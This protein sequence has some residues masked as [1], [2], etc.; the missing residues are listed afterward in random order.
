MQ[1]FRAPIRA[2]VVAL[3]TFL[4][5]DSVAASAP[6]AGAL[7]SGILL[8]GHDLAGVDHS[9]ALFQAGVP[10]AIEE[11]LTSTNGLV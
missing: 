2:F 11:N 10:I 9:D 8:Q 5:V 3:S 4:V 1:F 7:A 6:P